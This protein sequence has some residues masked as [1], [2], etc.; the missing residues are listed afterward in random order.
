MLSFIRIFVKEKF[1]K[2][3]VNVSD[4]NVVIVIIGIVGFFIVEFINIIKRGINKIILKLNI[5]DKFVNNLVIF[6]LFKF[7][8]VVGNINL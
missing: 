6:G 7:V 8:F 4:K 2:I 1:W 5:F 3:I